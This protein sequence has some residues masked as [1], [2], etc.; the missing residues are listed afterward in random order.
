LLQYCDE[1]MLVHDW[2]SSAALCRG[3]RRMP[4][5]L[6][7]ESQGGQVL[8]GTD[9]LLTDESC[10]LMLDVT[11]AQVVTAERYA[12]AVLS[13]MLNMPGWLCSI[14]QVCALR[15]GVVP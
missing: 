12:A 1:E 10:V 11:G 9:A 8:R 5:A 2:I 6:D 14:L 15:V 13:A 7:R 4:I 3:A